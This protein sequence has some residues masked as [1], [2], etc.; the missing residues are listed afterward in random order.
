MEYPENVITKNKRGEEEVRNLI[1]RGKFVMYDYRNPKTFK[2]MENNKIKLYLKDES[3]NTEEYYIIPTKTPNR[4]LLIRPKEIDN[5][6]R[7]VWNNKKKKE[8]ALWLD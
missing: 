7:F 6:T 2:Q 1:S 4:S 3:G 5:K 8:E